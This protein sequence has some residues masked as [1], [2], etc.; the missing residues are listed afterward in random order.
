L[1]I[2]NLVSD[3]SK[4]AGLPD[5][6]SVEQI[7]GGKNNRVYCVTYEDGTKALLK[8]YFQHPQDER[9]R[10]KSEHSFVNFAWNKNIKNVP[11]PLG[12]DI[13]NNLGLYEFID[14]NKPSLEDLDQSKIEEALDFFQ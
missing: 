10:L 5:E 2:K 11:K 14:G 13:K 7:K 3:L 12:V 9:N 6:F 1:L 4:N 8:A